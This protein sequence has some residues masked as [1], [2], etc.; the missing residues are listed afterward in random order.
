MTEEN[1]GSIFSKV[2]NMASQPEAGVPAPPP[3]PPAAQ[4]AVPPPPPAA[5]QPAAAPGR[6]PPVADP[7]I[8]AVR[9]E[10]AALRGEVETLRN[11]PLPELP[12]PPRE[13]EDFSFRLGRAEGMLGE[14]GRQLAAV[15][16]ASRARLEKTASKDELKN[17]DIR[18]GDLSGMLEGLK[19][20]FAREGEM[21]ARL[22]LAESALTELRTALSG[23]Q[24]RLKSGLEEMAPKEDL[25]PLRVGV[26]GARAAAEE[27][28]KSFAQFA[29]EFNAIEKQCHRAVG[30]VQGLAKAAEQDKGAEQFGE[31]LKEAVS[32]LNEKL[33]AAETVMHAGLTELSGRLKAN[34]VLYKK[35]FTEA[36]ERLRKSVE[37]QLKNMDGQLGWL[38]DNLLRLSDDYA[39]VTERKIKALEA[40]YSAFEVI[41]RRMDAIDAALKKSGRI[42]LP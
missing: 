40:K 17:F 37:P 35:M 4:Q 13:G 21:A 33:A 7:G 12:P 8:A 10:L 23:E 15:E 27:V 36:E 26:A 11:R 30:E 18:L 24:A 38:R 34:E 16:A 1:S 3:P 32:R 41:A 25:D 5:V 22:E 42:G 6:Q 31:Y 28:R 14:V 39:T 29:E 9:S 19:R 2:K 20:T